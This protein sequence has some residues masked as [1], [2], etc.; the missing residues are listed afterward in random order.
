MLEDLRS[1]Y[2]MDMGQLPI[3]KVQYVLVNSEMDEPMVQEQFP[4]LMEEWIPIDNVKQM[5]QLVN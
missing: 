5:D 4:I 1:L 2:Q 3:K